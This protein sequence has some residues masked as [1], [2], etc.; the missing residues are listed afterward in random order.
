MP[1]LPVLVSKGKLVASGIF[2]ISGR[3]LVIMTIGKDIYTLEL[4][5]FLSAIAVSTQWL[6]RMPVSYVRVVGLFVLSK[7]A[8][9][10]RNIRCWVGPSQK[11]RLRHCQLDCIYIICTER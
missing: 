11:S 4:R 1:V 10:V 5:L 6:C 9:T 7:H 8:F 2:R 3:G